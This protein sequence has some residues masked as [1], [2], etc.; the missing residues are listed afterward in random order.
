MSTLEE[1]V[2]K[3]TVDK[4]GFVSGL[5]DSLGS[6]EKWKKSMS[7]SLSGLDQ[8]FGTVVKSATAMGTSVAAAGT[9]MAVAMVKKGLDSVDAMAKLSDKTSIGMEALFGFKVAA[10]DVG[11]SL[12]SVTGAVTKLQRNISEAAAGNEV[13]AQA[14]VKIGLSAEALRQLQPEQAFGKVIDALNEVPN[15]A[16]AVAIKMQ[17]LGR[18]AVELTN[19]LAIGSKGLEE[20]TAKAEKLGITVNRFDAKKVEDANDAFAELGHVVDGVGQQMAIALAPFL[21]QGANDIADYF[22]KGKESVVSMESVVGTLGETIAVTADVFQ[23]FGIIVASVADMVA[24]ISSAFWNLIGIIHRTIEVVATLGIGYDTL[25]KILGATTDNIVSGFKVMASAIGVAAAETSEAIAS[26]IL[27]ASGDVLEDRSLS[28]AANAELERVKAEAV[29][30]GSAML[31]TMKN[32]KTSSVEESGIIADM[33]SAADERLEAA[34]ANLKKLT[35]YSYGNTVRD[36]LEAIRLKTEEA[37]KGFIDARTELEKFQTLMSKK[38]IGKFSTIPADDIVEFSPGFGEPRDLKKDTI[39]EKPKERGTGS[40]D[41]TGGFFEE[42]QAM[43][44]LEIGVEE[45]KFD[46]MR[47]LASTFNNDMAAEDAR[48]MA[49]RKQGAAGQIVLAQEVF[50]TLSTLMNS[51][52]KKQFQ[53]GKAAAIA[54][55]VVNTAQGATKAFAQ[56]GFYGFAMA[57]AVVAAGAAQIQQIKA[58]QFNGGGSGNGGQVG[59]ASTFNAEQVDSSSNTGGPGR[60]GQNNVNVTLLGDTFS[61]KQVRGLVDQLSGA[62]GDGAVI[63]VNGG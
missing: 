52:E 19:F 13:M 17:L 57:A 40:I 2:V 1:L 5:N 6:A 12:E 16:D 54:N 59:Q 56:G 47:E 61:Q 25:G 22:L 39:F 35:T 3:I 32:L 53:I 4:V 45:E 26:T 44:D 24:F 37:K 60:G 31:E 63:R 23:G 27:D 41:A 62:A 50:G 15:K 51:H 33:A 8:A 10:D 48:V 11:V 38:P 18:S 28:E 46:A 42:L 58:T 49:L 30:T 55:A 9:A 34:R 14:F 29:L 20:Y 7:V 43:K 21:H 36:A